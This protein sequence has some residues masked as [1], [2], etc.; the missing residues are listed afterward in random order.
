[1]DERRRS[2]QVGAGFT[3]PV[4]VADARAEPGQ[5]LGD[6]RPRRL[7]VAHGQPEIQCL[8]GHDEFDREDPL[9]VP[10]LMKTAS[11]VLANVR[12]GSASL[13]D[14][15]EKVNTGQGTLGA[16]V[17]DK[18]MYTQIDQTTAAARSGATAFQENMDALKHNFLLRGFFNDRGYQDS[19]KLAQDEIPKL[20]PVRPPPGSPKLG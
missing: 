4:E 5:R 9:D 20:P 11:A 2:G 12:D 15:A 3:I 6:T 19:A 7:A 1:V 18:R 8:G 17:N 16:L 14:I 10:D 13:K